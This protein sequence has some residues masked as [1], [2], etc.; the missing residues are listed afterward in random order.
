MSEEM[1]RRGREKPTKT[2]LVS[3]LIPVYNTPSYFLNLA[4]WSAQRQSYREIE[5]II[6][7]DGS[8]RK[9]TLDILEQYKEKKRFKVIHQDNKGTAGALNT[10]LD[11][12]KGELIDIFASDDILMPHRTRNRVKEMTRRKNRKAGLLYDN[13]CQLHNPCSLKLDSP[14]FIHPIDIRKTVEDLARVSRVEFDLKKKNLSFD[15]RLEKL[16]MTSEQ[17]AGFLGKLSGPIK[18]VGDCLTFKDTTLLE[19][20]DYVCGA[21][22][23]RREVYDSVGRF[24]YTG[25]R[26]GNRHSEDYNMILRI[27][28]VYPG[29]Y[30]ECNPWESWV[31]RRWGGSKSV[32]DKEGVDKCRA[33]VQETM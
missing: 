27:A 13:F 22:M 33:K 23:T 7:D 9:P 16:G 28:R 19:H 12:S 3:M 10:G 15:K 25:Y 29:V 6:I 21:N 26:E 5:F 8:T 31:Y 24:G 30:H 4:L 14:P 17:H 18:N 20:H 32:S 1:S 2:P 11:H